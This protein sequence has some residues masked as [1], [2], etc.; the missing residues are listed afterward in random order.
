MIDRGF[1]K[2]RVSGGWEL[3]QN[4]SRIYSG[5][6]GHLHIAMLPLIVCVPGGWTWQVS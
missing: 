3:S 2:Q 6:V 1:I 5:E 4:G